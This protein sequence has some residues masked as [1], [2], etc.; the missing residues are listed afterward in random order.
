[1]EVELQYVVSGFRLLDEMR[2]E[3]ELEAEAEVGTE[4][5]VHGPLLWKAAEPKGPR[6]LSQYKC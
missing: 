4:A 1:V 6:W 3:L 5:E 2:M